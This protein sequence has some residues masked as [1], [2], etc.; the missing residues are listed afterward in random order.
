MKFMSNMSFVLILTMCRSYAHERETFVKNAS[1]W[2]W[3]CH[4]LIYPYL[5]CWWC[6]CSSCGYLACLSIKILAWCSALCILEKHML[7]F[8]DLIHALPTSWGVPN[9]CFP[10]WVLHQVKEIWEK[11]IC[12][13]GSCIHSLGALFCLNFSCALLSMMSSPFASPWGVGNL[14]AFYLGCVKP[15]PLP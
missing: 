2:S 11:C 14:G 1:F 7:V 6:L 4:L 10:V 5:S 3:L 12:S 13:G 15:L 9:S 8:V